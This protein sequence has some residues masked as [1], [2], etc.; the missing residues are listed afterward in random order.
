MI[1]DEPQ[2]EVSKPVKE[3][4]IN[5]AARLKLVLFE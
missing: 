5:E 2:Y 3:E 1:S 4:L